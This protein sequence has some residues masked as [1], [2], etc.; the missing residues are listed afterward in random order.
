[1]AGKHVCFPSSLDIEA[2]SKVILESKFLEMW[3]FSFEKRNKTVLPFG[4]TT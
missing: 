2:F 4:A 3:V 1:M